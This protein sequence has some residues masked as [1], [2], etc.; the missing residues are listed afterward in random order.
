MPAARLPENLPSIEYLCEAFSY[1]PA[2]GD[3]TWRERPVH[4]FVDADYQRRFT[5]RY[6]GIAAGSRDRR[7]YLLISLNHRKYWVHR[8]C[9]AIHTGRWP[10]HFIDHINGIRHDNRAENLRDV[11]QLINGKGAVK[12][13]NNTSGYTGVGWRQ[14]GNK[15][16]AYITVRGR[17]IHLG[18]FGDLADAV[19]ARKAACERFGFSEYH[20]QDN[21]N[22]EIDASPGSLRSNNTSGYTGVTL[23]KGW[24]AANITIDGVVHRL[25]SYRTK[26]EAAEARRAAEIKYGVS[27]MSL[28]GNGPPAITPTNKE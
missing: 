9:W 10:E 1:D 2:T 6:Y 17:R 14:K 7:G 24:W 19:A 18:L 12:S 3:L 28:L 21:P 8:I 20:G 13:K 27:K 25:S 26:E 5:A 4:H 15:W 23:H 16:L 22:E 11:P